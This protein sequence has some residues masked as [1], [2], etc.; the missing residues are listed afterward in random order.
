VEERGSPKPPPAEKKEA[1]PGAAAVSRGEKLLRRGK[2]DDALAAFLEAL[3]AE[4]DLPAAVRGLGMVYM[5]QGKEA[6]AKQQ[7]RRYL[8][9]APRA[10]DAA[11]I[12]KLVANL[13]S[14]P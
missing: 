5:M 11:R 2:T 12:R 3:A 14:S 13:G 6:E 1:S 4:P 7:Y 9:L 8:K 10:R